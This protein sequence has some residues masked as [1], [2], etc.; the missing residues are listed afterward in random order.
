MADAF[1]SYSRRDKAFALALKTAIEADGFEVLFD[2]EDILGSEDWARRLVDMIAAADHVVFVISPDSCQS[3]VCSVEITTALELSKSIVPVAFRQTAA[4]IVPVPIAQRQWIDCL[5]DSDPNRCAKALGALF[6]TSPAWL[7]QHTDLTTRA[8]DW[9]LA[10]RRSALLRGSDL[11]RAEVWLAEADGREPPPSA[12]QVEYIAT[13]RKWRRTS[14]LIGAALLA[15]ATSAAAIGLVAIDDQ[16]KLSA[17][18]RLVSVA[19]D[20]MERDPT[21][22]ALVMLEVKRPGRTPYATATLMQLVTRPIASCELGGHTR[23]VTTVEFSPTG[24]HFLTLS[25]NGTVRLWPAAEC[26]A[27]PLREMTIPKD[28]IERAFFTSDGKAVVLFAIRG[29]ARLWH[30]D[31]N[32]VDEPLPIDLEAAWLTRSGDVLVLR[33]DFTVE[34][35]ASTPGLVRKNA[36]T[37]FAHLPGYGATERALFSPAS[38][39]L[40]LRTHGGAVAIWTVGDSHDA[41]CC[42]AE[43]SWRSVPTAGRTRARC[44][45]SSAVENT[46]AGTTC[47]CGRRQPPGSRRTEYRERTCGRRSTMN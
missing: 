10:R 7:R 12:S 33:D 34:L 14:R 15:A 16:R 8:R 39:R 46:A 5:A 19:G 3:R 35:W 2:L 31:T 40:L 22:S 42:R 36:F 28:A 27:R 6:K 44:S 38:D 4:E 24:T 11:R 18:N 29:G 25:G 32:V 23:G 30:I 20:W 43:I 37:P 45:R 9:H 21:R 13:S 47:W 1:I 41:N 17:D 26:H